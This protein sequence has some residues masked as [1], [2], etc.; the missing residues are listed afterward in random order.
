MDEAPKNTNANDE[1]KNEKPA[2]VV[3][4]DEKDKEK[5]DDKVDAGAGKL[6]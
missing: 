6:N 1:N 3:S 5:K 2:A 4:G